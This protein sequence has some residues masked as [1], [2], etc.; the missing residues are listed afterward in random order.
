VENVVSIF[1]LFSSCG[2]SLAA[3]DYG[4]GDVFTAIL[5]PKRIHAQMYRIQMKA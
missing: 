5:L 4:R 1:H 2:Q 3:Q